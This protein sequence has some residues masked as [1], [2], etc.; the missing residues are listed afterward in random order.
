M[1]VIYNI[2]C[3]A[4]NPRKIRV[5]GFGDKGSLSHE[6]ERDVIGF[7]RHDII[8][9]FNTLIHNRFGTIMGSMRKP[10]T[11]VSIFVLEQPQQIVFVFFDAASFG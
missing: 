7:A 5:D 11:I 10:D 9:K 3:L 6:I 2:S 8:A 1:R 4:I